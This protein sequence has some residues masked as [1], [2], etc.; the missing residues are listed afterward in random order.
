MLL[1]GD[2]HEA[3][4]SIQKKEQIQHTLWLK[5]INHTWFFLATRIGYSKYLGFLGRHLRDF[6][7][8]LV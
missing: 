7:L 3:S 1:C 4:Q 2:D 5:K 8:N 6:I